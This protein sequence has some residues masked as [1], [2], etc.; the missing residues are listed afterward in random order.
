M[1][2]RLLPA[3]LCTLAW[4]QAGDAQSLLD[5]VATVWD[6]SAV[7]ALER[8]FL[9]ATAGS[10]DIT[11]RDLAVPAP[12]AGVRAAVTRGSIVVATLQ[13]PPGQAGPAV[14]RADLVSGN[15]SVRV[16]G[17]PSTA[18]RSGTIGISVVR[19]G[20]STEILQF[21]DALSLAPPAVPANTTVLER[22]FAVADTS[23]HTLQLRDL[24]FPAAA[25]SVQL[26]MTR[27]GA[28]IGLPLSAAGAFTFQGQPQG[29]GD[30]PY[31]LRVITTA[32]TVSGGA[33]ATI[34]IRSAS[35]AVV[36]SESAPAGQVRNAGNASLSAG[37]HT[38][39]LA[40]LVFPSALAQAQAIGVLAGAEA[41]RITSPGNAGFS[42]SAGMHRLFVLARPGS[43]PGAGSFGVDILQ[44]ASVVF[45]SADVVNLGNGAARGFALSA[46]VPTAGDYRLR[47]FDYRFPN[48][49]STL[50]VAAVRGGNTL[51]SIA[52]PGDTTLAALP[53]GSVVVL[54][55]AAPG[56]TTGGGVYGLQLAPSSG[57]AA[58]LDV[59]QG[60]GA[61]FSSRRID[62]PASG[63]FNVTAEDLGFPAT[64]IELFA[65]VTRG[66]D[67][68]GSI[69]GGGT[70]S[71]DA[72]P[73]P[74]NVS[75]IARPDLFEK[76]G[77]YRLGVA[78]TPAAPTVGFSASPLSVS[79]GA[80]STLNW[81]SQ[82]ATACT[83][84]GAWSGSRPTSGTE[85]SPPVTSSASFTL[86]CTGP[87]GSTAATAS[88]TVGAPP[89]GGG[90]G[91]GRMDGL[92]LLLLTTLWLV[93]AARRRAACSRRTAITV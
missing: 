27:G 50:R 72:L 49:F 40:D 69:F 82:N 19:V 71:F 34:H 81:T 14:I 75:F 39:R 17:A 3:L 45:S 53:A 16:V 52:A 48:A 70:F 7:A 80:T 23:V 84:S 83:A 85:A 55:L 68:V 41:V 28:V 77:T 78:P 76:A 36:L 10:H 74:Y 91:G 47:L 86:T 13:I 5:E 73:G 90:G 6:D 87:G 46:N 60:V 58:V 9:V 12:L 92:M 42:A 26:I 56:G 62:V 79:S 44:G 31:T 2:R 65:L 63:R 89:I 8:P 22:N 37:P 15:Y 66:P 93:Q 24:G 29:A 4:P 38:L 30:P 57:G 64:F 54:A 67:S 20:D 51:G 33:L 43:D 88:V 61:L 11:L 21:A 25:Q 32:T 35:G 59:N 18:A 1:Q